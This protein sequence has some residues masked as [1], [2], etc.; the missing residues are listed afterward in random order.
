MVVYCAAHE[1]ARSGLRLGLEA[2][3][4]VAG[5]RDGEHTDAEE[6]A[7]RGAEVNVA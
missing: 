5:V 1:R 7:A 3:I 2:N 6:L 4:G